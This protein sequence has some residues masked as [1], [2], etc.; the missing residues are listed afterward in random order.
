MAI[1]NYTTSIL[2]DAT[3]AEISRILARAGART[4]SVDYDADG[5]PVSVAFAVEITGRWINFRLPSNHTGVLA[6][7][8]KDASIPRK[9]KTEFQ[10]RRVAWRITKDWCA[11]QIA[12]IEAHQAE[13][14]EVFLPYAIMGN[15]QTLFQQ[16]KTDRLMLGDGGER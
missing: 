1:L 16:F 5:N 3:I 12:I 10:A 9:F 15:G 8:V 6:A 7:L 14:A 13:L 11:A 4:I 2:P